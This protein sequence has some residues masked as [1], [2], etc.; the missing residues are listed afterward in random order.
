MFRRI[1]MAALALLIAAPLAAQAPA[2]WQMRVDQ[3]TNAADPDDVPEVTFPEVSSGF[4]VST[5]PA[6]TLWNPDNTASGSFTLKGT[7]TMHEPSSHANYYGL[8]YGG[9]DLAG[10]GQNYLYFLVAQNGTFLVKH[11]ANNDTTHDVQARTEHSAVATPGENGHSTNVLEV[12]VSAN[13]TEFVIN[14]TVV[15][16]APKSGMA[17]RAD[18]NWG[19]RVNHVLPS[20]HVSDLSVTR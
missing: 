16:T 8:V 19:V 6:V 5:G 13:Q 20:I 7:F 11:R 15:H 14:G 10:S 2:G 3:S 1:S 17:A 9:G 12:R 18:G 4:R